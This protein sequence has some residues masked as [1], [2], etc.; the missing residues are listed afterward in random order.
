MRKLIVCS[1]TCL[2][3]VSA[4]AANWIETVSDNQGVISYIDIDS[5]N[6]FNEN[7]QIVTAFFKYE[8]LSKAKKRI[9]NKVVDSTSS[10][11]AF[12][13]ES[14]SSYMLS[15][16]FYDSNGISLDSFSRSIDGSFSSFKAL[17]PDTLGYA[18]MYAAC[19]VAGFKDISDL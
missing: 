8:N 6:I 17:H 1:L 3:S 14:E 10:K 9:N 13:C 18:D 5:V 19:A 2:I 15:G 7:T 11:I 16:I 12:N 4:S